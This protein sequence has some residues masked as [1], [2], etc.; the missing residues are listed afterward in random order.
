MEN[1]LDYLVKVSS[2]KEYSKTRH[3]NDIRVCEDLRYPKHVIDAV[4]KEKDE[5]KRQHIMTTARKKYL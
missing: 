1:D 4:V 2:N 5:V 3:R